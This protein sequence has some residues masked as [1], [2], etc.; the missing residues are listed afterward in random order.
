MIHGAETLYGCCLASSYEGKK[1]P[2]GAC[3]IDTVLANASK[4]HEG[5]EVAESTRLMI[6]VCGGYIADLSSNHDFDNLELGPL[7]TKY[8][9][10][11][12][13]VP[14]ENESRY[15]G[16]RKNWRLKA[17]IPFR[18]SMAVVHLRRIGLRF[19]ARAMLRVKRRRPNVWPASKADL[20]ENVLL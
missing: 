10:A 3:F 4:I 13:T 19:S 6:D 2:S 14:I 18:I 16:L 11:V 15:T 7:L 9:K 17:R 5:K 20:H 8:L 1:Q 12:D